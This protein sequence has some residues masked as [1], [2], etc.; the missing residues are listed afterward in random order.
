MRGS[1]PVTNRLST[2]TPQFVEAVSEVRA[3]AVLVAGLGGTGCGANACAGELR[4]LR[5]GLRR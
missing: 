1:R 4:Y 5:S 2:L 3:I